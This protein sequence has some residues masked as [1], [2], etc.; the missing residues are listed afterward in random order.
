MGWRKELSIC[1]KA[2]NAALQTK[3]EYRADFVLGLTGAIGF[4]AASLGML[5]V[6]LHSTELLG[7]WRGPE[8]LLLFGLTALTQGLS[9]LFFNHIWYVPLYVVRGQ[10][11]RLLTYPVSTLPFFLVTSPEL[12]AFGNL[13]AGLTLFSV[14]AIKLGL[15]WTVWALLPWWAVC[16][17]LIHTAVLTLCGALS[18]K[19]VGSYG[20]HYWVSNAL[21]QASRYPLN[22]Y[23]R[24]MQ[25]LLLVLLPFGLINYVPAS[26]L[27]QRLPLALAIIAPALAAALCVS[28]AWTAFNHGLR[29]YESSGS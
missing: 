3:L 15:P 27:T 14:G 18:F 28:V 21:L 6:L 10:F 12:H 4:Q 11:D 23:P 9:E 29:Y 19:I 24:F 26:A 20:Q 25:G 2:F 17:C 7:G 1:F 8:I 22:I 16:G 13:I 5:S